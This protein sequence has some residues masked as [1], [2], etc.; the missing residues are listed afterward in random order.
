MVRRAPSYYRVA[1][2]DLRA[3]IERLRR[4]AVFADGPLALAAPELKVRRASRRPNRVGFAVPAEQRLS[5][6]A[7]PEIGA[8]DVLETLLHE[9][10]HLHVGRRP[11]AHAWHGQLFKRTLSRAMAEAYGVRGVRPR[12]SL[13]GA[14][15]AAIARRRRPADLFG[16]HEDGKPMQTTRERSAEMLALTQ[17]A[18]EAV[19][20]MVN[21][22]EVPENA[23]VRIASAEGEIDATQTE[24]Q[25]V[26]V[27]EPEE[28]DLLI[29]GVP[30][31]VERETI[32]LLQDKI[33]DAE[34]TGSGVSFSLYLQPQAASANGGEPPA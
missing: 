21:R 24:L 27:E 10:C 28:N 2:I 18:A 34:M 13:H 20:S 1:G 14:Y 25:M 15:A 8:G 26:L 16:D 3:E 12:N 22:P 29:E 6:T 7:Y 30:I 17:N 33:L 4:L 9:L 31:S 32:G 19:E 23:V 5:I 11:G